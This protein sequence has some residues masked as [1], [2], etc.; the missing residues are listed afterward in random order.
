MATIKIVNNALEAIDYIIPFSYTNKTINIVVKAPIQSSVFLNTNV[1]GDYNIPM[2]FKEQTEEG[3][4]FT[5]DLTLLKTQV[6]YLKQHPK[7]VLVFKVY[8]NN[9]LIEGEFRG[10]I[11]PQLYN[12]FIKNEYNTLKQIQDE[13]IKLNS[14]I[15]ILNA[16]KVPFEETPKTLYKGMVP[17]STGVYNEYKWDFPFSDLR[18][19]VKSLSE[20]VLNLSQQNSKLTSRLSTLEEK[21][22]EHIY[23]QYQ[24]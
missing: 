19:T 11:N 9:T 10:S 16:P 24:L 8:I 6:E 21:V 4:M 7:T 12:T 2:F 23:E 5:C 15:A 22:N 3:N 13:L 20:L 18:E 1:N 14:K 17:I